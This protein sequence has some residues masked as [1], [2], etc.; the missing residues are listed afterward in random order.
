MQRPNLLP[1]IDIAGATLKKLLFPVQRVSVIEASTGSREAA[2]FFFFFFFLWGGGELV[3][4][5]CPFLEKLFFF[6]RMKKKVPIRTFF[7]HPA[8]TPE[9]DGFF[10]VWPGPRP[11]YFSC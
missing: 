7:N 4:K 11:T 1:S 2:F 3:G 10:L 6:A 8:A 9:T 5:Y